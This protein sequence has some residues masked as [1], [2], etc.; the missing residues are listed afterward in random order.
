M[1][2]GDLQRQRPRLRQREP[3]RRCVIEVLSKH[4]ALK[5]DKI[6]ML[7]TLSKWK[8]ITHEAYS[9]LKD[10][11]DNLNDREF[12]IQILKYVEFN[13]FCLLLE[14][15]RY[16]YLADQ[17][18]TK[19]YTLLYQ[20]H[21]KT[22]IPYSKRTHAYYRIL[23]SCVDNDSFTTTKTDQLKK[24]IHKLDDK[25]VS[26]VLTSHE[27]QFAMEKKVAATALLITQYTAYKERK[28]ILESAIKTETSGLDNTSMQIVFHSKMAMTEI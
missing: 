23:K 1:E 7:E 12:L 20:N 28:Q 26:K 19:R 2:E 18:K 6:G 13:S 16:Q 9:E 22:V 3:D 17:L 15:E 21:S 25:I 4:A 5:I 27:R 11:C 10:S 8:V 14:K 24:F